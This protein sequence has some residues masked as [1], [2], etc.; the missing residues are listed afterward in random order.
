MTSQLPRVVLVLLLLVSAASRLAAADVRPTQAQLEEA[1]QKHL[2]A[3]Q[4]GD[5][6]AANRLE[7]ELRLLEARAGTTLSATPAPAMPPPAPSFF[8]AP[9]GASGTQLPTSSSVF[10]PPAATPG[11]LTP[12]PVAPAT[13]TVTKGK[14]PAAASPAPAPSPARKTFPTTPVVPA[15]AA[16][17]VTPPA[18]LVRTTNPPA[19]FTTIAPTAFEEPRPAD[20]PPAV[21]ELRAAQDALS[22][23]EDFRMAESLTTRRGAALPGSAVVPPPSAVMAP[24]PFTLTP[25]PSVNL[26]GGTEDFRRRLDDLTRRRTALQTEAERLA[27]DGVDW[28]ARYAAAKAELARLE[29]QNQ[30]RG[31]LQGIRDELARLDADTTRLVQEMEASR[32]E[33]DRRAREV[34][35]RMEPAPSPRL[36]PRELPLAATSLPAMSFSLPAATPPAAAPPPEKKGPPTFAAVGSSRPQRIVS[37]GNIVRTGRTGEDAA[38]I[39]RELTQLN[40][41]RELLLR[42]ADDV[43]TK[44]NL[45][46]REL[47]TATRTGIQADIDRWTK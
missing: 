5:F 37:E 41:K 34:L 43:Q 17:A 30:E 19:A 40:E 3:L 10:T 27:K 15:P 2:Q 6:T 47:A 32:V 4:R 16:P 42:E 24:A 36:T 1:K 45:A 44:F 18:S 38:V 33:Q 20:V 12:I 28:E 23:L 31:R 25:A 22:K 21:V 7:A 39:E 9:A 35:T 26:A 46:Q 8:S 13:T 14:A 11:A 29:A